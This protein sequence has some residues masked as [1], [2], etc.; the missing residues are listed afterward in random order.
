MNVIDLRS[1]T[2]TLPTEDMRK[3]I[4]NAT[5]GDD[6]SGEDPTVNKLEEM[7]AAMMGKEAALLVS[8]GTQGNDEPLPDLPEFWGSAS[9]WLGDVRG[10]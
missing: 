10:S 3:A 2:V 8:S 4:W 5:L 9:S 7:A 1:D 6:V